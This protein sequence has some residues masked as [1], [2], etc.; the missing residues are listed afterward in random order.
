MRFSGPE[1]Y[2]LRFDAYL[3]ATAITPLG[4]KLE[5]LVRNDTP[6]LQIN[7][8]DTV[9]FRGGAMLPPPLDPEEIL[10]SND[11]V[12]SDFALGLPMRAVA[13]AL[14]DSGMSLPSIFPGD[15]FGLESVGEET[16][17]DQQSEDA[18]SRPGDELSD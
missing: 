4:R 15:A 11:S 16:T 1:S 14:L 17:P 2:F 3:D 5:K 9:Y 12:P 13:A 8:G 10:P 6:S 7:E 18:Q